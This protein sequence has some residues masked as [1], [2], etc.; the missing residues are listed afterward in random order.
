M[1]LTRVQRK[2]G[3]K[4]HVT[5][6]KKSVRKIK[7]DHSQSKNTFIYIT[8]ITSAN[9]NLLYRATVLIRLVLTSEATSRVSRGSLS[10][11][12]SQ[13]ISSLKFQNVRSQRQ[14]ESAGI[15]GA[16]IS[17]VTPATTVGSKNARSVFRV[18]ETPLPAA[19]GRSFQFNVSSRSVRVEEANVKVS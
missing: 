18:I 8:W 11:L 13:T 6:Q 19:T 2:N 1:S 14:H 10:A 3:P 12:S 7:R 16:W 4:S 5:R 15:R 17:S 9:K